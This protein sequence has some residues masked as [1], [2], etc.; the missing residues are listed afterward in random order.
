[1]PDNWPDVLFLDD[2]LLVINK[3]A[4]LGTLPDGYDPSLP[5]VKSL[6]EPE[7]G[8]LW[9]V[10]RL[11]KDTSG[12]LLLARTAAAHRNLNMQFEH[13]EVEKV[14]HALV[15]GEAS[16]EEKTI[17]LLLH[18]NGDRRH[19]TVVDAARGKPA[20]T[21]LRVLQRF[22]G[23]TL[24]EARPR[25]GRTHQIRAHLAASGLPLVGDAL[26]GGPPALYLSDLIPGSSQ[27]ADE[28]PLITRPALHARAAG[29]LHPASGERLY[30]E[31]PYPEEFSV[32][33]GECSL[34]LA[35]GEGLG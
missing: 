15:K 14:Y 13:G 19:R 6:L 1:M 27:E 9:I 10:H 30:V 22:S 25:T 32:T 23:Y 12:V 4:G 35:H 20:L 8:R 11:D 28:Q 16:W 3:P 33:L 26:Y 17:D 2:P 24:L 21:V 7:Y 18:P 5:H 31:A 29:F 34:H